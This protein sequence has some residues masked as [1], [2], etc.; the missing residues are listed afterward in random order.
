VFEMLFSGV[1]FYYTLIGGF[2][3]GLSATM[4]LL[5]N[6]RIAGV[7][8]IAFGLFNQSVGDKL[9]RWLFLFGLTS[10]VITLHLLTKIP[11]P[12]PSSASL[13][14]LILGG[15]LVGFGTQFGSGCT[16]GHGVCGISRFSNRSIISTLLFI[17][18]GLISMLLFRHFFGV[19]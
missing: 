1:N 19:I 9:W 3:I 14:I 4:L 5:F 8:G 2:L 7:C 16:S 18:F 13:P 17:I 6:G 12:T 15:F 11:A 10:G